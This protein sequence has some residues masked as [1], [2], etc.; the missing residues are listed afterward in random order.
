MTVDV[1]AARETLERRERERKKRLLRRWETADADARKII[2]HIVKHFRPARVWQWGSVLR[3][4]RFSE[5]SDIDIAVEGLDSAEAFLRLLG[6]CQAMTEF[7]LDVIELEKI[8]PGFAELIKSQGKL[9][10]E[11]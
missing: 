6:E 1:K 7:D 4:E 9:V 8:E 11:R 5:I 2:A 3:K 10:Y